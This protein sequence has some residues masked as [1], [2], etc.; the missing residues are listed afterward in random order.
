L[1][2]TVQLTINGRIIS[3]VSTYVHSMQPA[4]GLPLLVVF[5]VLASTSFG[6]QLQQRPSA[7]DGLPE[8]VP[9]P[10]LLGNSKYRNPQVRVLSCQCAAAAAV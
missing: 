1:A 7:E 2:R 8:L 3:F 10:L 6:A 4:V 9:L 5:M